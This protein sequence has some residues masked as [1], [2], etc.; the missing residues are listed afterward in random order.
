MPPALY[1]DTARPYHFMRVRPSPDGLFPDIVL[2]GGEDHRTGQADDPERRFARLEQWARDRLPDAGVVAYR[3]SGQ[4]VEPVDS[5]GFI[6]RNPGVVP[7]I[8]VATGDSGNG[9]T[10]GTIAGILLT[11][12]IAG[13]DNPWSKLYDPSRRSVRTA[14]EF[15]RENLNVAGRY[16]RWVTPGEVRAVTDIPP[17][18]GAVIRRGI[19][20]IACYRDD[21]GHMHEYSAVCPHLFCLVEWNSTEHT[22]DCPCHGS[23]FDPYG[24][25]INGPA[26]NNLPPIV[27]D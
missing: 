2:V 3:W 10:N 11:D 8:Y 1:W 12:L 5:L 24:T 7:N 23:R 18:Q 27:E 22:W 15:V 19:H 14:T 16:A 4:I 20:K 25:V 9:L 17:G 13:R 21:A 6:G 26:V